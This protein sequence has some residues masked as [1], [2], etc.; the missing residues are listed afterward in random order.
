[1]NKQ[2]LW[3]LSLRELKKL[4]CSW[5][6]PAYRAD[7]VYHW[8][9]RRL[10]LSVDQ[11]TNL[12][13]QL[14]QRLKDEMIL[15]SLTVAQSHC[16]ADAKALKLLFSAGD[17]QAIEGV[18]LKYRRWVS[19][20]LSSQAGCRMGCA[21][22]ASA[23]GGLVRNLTVGEMTGQLVYLTKG[24]QRQGADLRSLVLMGTGEPL[25]NYNNV[26]SFLAQVTQAEG[27]DLSYRR[28]TLSTCGL[29]PEIRCLAQ[30]KLPLTLA[31]SLH[32][33]TDDLRTELMPIN[34][35]YPVAELIAA[36][37]E[38]VQATGRRLTFEYTLLAQVNDSPQQAHQL[39][40]LV[41]GLACHVNLIPFNPVLRSRFKTP[42]PGD[43]QI[44]QQVLQDRGVPVT[45]RRELGQD[46]SAACGQLRHQVLKKRM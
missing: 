40:D 15:P 11:M 6:E 34:S 12:P 3:G 35:A 27:F 33:P 39:A 22:C 24:A 7:Q 43:V 36:C 23:S 21:F 31:V 19:A 2:D 38:Y 4:L 1:M 17:G 13:I 25:D 10:V 46:I 37:H 29:V 5:G 28:I 44:F 42:A 32:A 9:Y 45:V 18:L 26:L 8:L 14:R 20:C 41:Q 16:S 30:E